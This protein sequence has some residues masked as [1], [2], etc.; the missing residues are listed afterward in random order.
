M[1]RDENP[2]AVLGLGI[3]SGG[4]KAKRSQAVVIRDER[5]RN[6][7]SFYFVCKIVDNGRLNIMT[8]W[9]TRAHGIAAWQGRYIGVT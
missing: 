8:C 3:R 9:L 6:L 4:T 2:V 5:G 7:L 1:R